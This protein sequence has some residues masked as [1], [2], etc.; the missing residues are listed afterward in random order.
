[1]ILALLLR[2]GKKLSGL[3]DFYRRESNV[4]MRCVNVHQ[5]VSYLFKYYRLEEE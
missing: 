2:Y 3:P 4:I 1:M 5:V